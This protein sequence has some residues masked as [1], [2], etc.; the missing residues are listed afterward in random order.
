MNHKAKSGKSIDESFRD[1]HQKNPHVYKH[2]K[3]YFEMLHHRKGWQRVSA[4]LIIERVR[5]EIWSS[6]DSLDFKINNNYTSRYVRMFIKDYPQYEHCFELRS[7]K[8]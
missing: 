3:D 8:S 6:A 2:F 1:F 4:K 5:W 7:L